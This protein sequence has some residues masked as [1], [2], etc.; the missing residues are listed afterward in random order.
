MVCKFKYTSDYSGCWLHM[1]LGH[2]QCLDSAYSGQN[3]GKC[4]SEK[5]LG[6]AQA[7]GRG[8]TL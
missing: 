5:V 4:I 3:L 1:G 6:E 7:I 8:P 2:H